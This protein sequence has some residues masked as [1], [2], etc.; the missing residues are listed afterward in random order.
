M[1][2]EESIDQ[3]ICFLNGIDLPEMSIFYCGCALHMLTNE[4]V[5][6]HAS[7][8][9]FNMPED[10]LDVSDNDDLKEDNTEQEVDQIPSIS[11]LFLMGLS[12][13]SSC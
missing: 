3:I 12:A 9:D 7:A 5:L 11:V 4:D 2:D 1:T 6:M 10:D 13:V 8:D